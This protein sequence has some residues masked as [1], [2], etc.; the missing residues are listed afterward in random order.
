[1]SLGKGETG[2]RAACPI[3]LYFMEQTLKGEPVLA[4]KIP[5][6]IHFARVGGSEDSPGVYVPFSGDAPKGRV[7]P[8]PTEDDS[9]SSTATS[10]LNGASDSFFKSDLF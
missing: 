9:S 1:V 5:S 4:F 6:G 8:R 3:W 10:R 7:R 2:G